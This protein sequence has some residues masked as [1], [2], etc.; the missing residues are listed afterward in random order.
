MAFGFA[1]AGAGAADSL[2]KILAEQMIR[3]QLA[4]RQ[5]EQ[6]DQ[7]AL[8]TQRLNQDAIEGDARIKQGQQQIDMQAGDRRERNNIRGVRRMLGESITQRT[9]PMTSDDRRGMA[10]LQVEAG[11]DPT[12]LNEPKQERDPIADHEAKARIDAKYRPKPTGPAAMRTPLWVRQPDGSVV[13][14]NGVAPPGSVPYDPVAAR[15]SK[16]VDDKEAMDTAREAKRIAMALRSHEGMGGAFGV[17]DSWLPTMKQSTADAEALRDSLRSLLTIENMGKM[18]G[19]LSDADMKV[20][21]AASTTLSNQMSDSAA[22]LELER[23]A[24]VMSKALGEQDPYPD[25]PGG[26]GGAAVDPRVQEMIRK[27][28]GGG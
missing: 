22:R 18:K 27:Y 5:K 4:Q 21:Q 16:P 6:A 26:G 14:V 10:A 9:G 24:R 17:L 20:L 3:A 11:D 1:G 7:V 8:Q 12:L 2:E 28:G 23:L 19:V 25:Q 13:D 15:S